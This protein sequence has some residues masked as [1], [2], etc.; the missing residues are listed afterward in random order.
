LT[1]SISF[2]AFTLFMSNAWLQNPLGMAFN[3]HAYRLE[4][5]DYSLLLHNPILF[6]KALH[7]F[8]ASYV[9]AALTI[10]AL[11]ASLLL[12]NPQHVFARSSF[13]LAACLGLVSSLLLCTG[14]TTPQLTTP[15]QA[16]KLAALANSAPQTA[17]A[18]LESHIRKGIQAYTLLEQLRDEKTDPQL[19]SDFEALQADLGYGLLLKRHSEAISDASE[20]QIAQALQEA[21]P[22][23]AS[24]LYWAKV[25]MLP[26][27][28]LVIAWFVLALLLARANQ[29]LAHLFL[30]LTQYL[31][32]LSWL[33]SIVGWYIAEAGIQPWAI[34]GALPSFLAPSSLTVTEAVIYLSTSV[35]IMLALLGIAGFLGRKLLIANHTQ[36]QGAQA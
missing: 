30:T 36:L 2:S 6:S 17:S 5:T 25:I 35:I 20:A 10:M 24:R 16:I 23:S 19:V 22:A 28:Y 14:D 8:A 32:A 34:A 27:G 33:A 1:L 18:Q 21:H 11:S 4:L 15:T 26:V 3:S 7:G 31:A 29:T 13:K 12:Q 9:T